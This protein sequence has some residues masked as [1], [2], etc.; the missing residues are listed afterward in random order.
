LLGQLD[1]IV[2]LQ[3]VLSCVNFFNGLKLSVC[4]EPLRLSAGLS[5][6]AMI[7]PIDLGHALRLLSIM[8]LQGLEWDVA[9]GSR[10]N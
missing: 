2:F 10:P 5:A 1:R 3:R 6:R 8:L 9:N 7:A 4:K